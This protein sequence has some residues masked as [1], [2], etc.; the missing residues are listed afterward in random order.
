MDMKRG[1]GRDQGL[2]L[3]DPAA[4]APLGDWRARIAAAHARIAARVRR[5]PVLQLAAGSFGFDFDLALKLETCQHTGSY[6]PRGVFNRLLAR[7]D[8]NGSR[9][10]V[11]A[12]GGNHGIA[13]AHA[14]STLGFAA[15]VFVP[16]LT[17]PE[18]LRQI[19]ELGGEVMVSGANYGEALAASERHARETGALSIHAFDEPELIEGQG[20]VALELDQQAG[21]PDTVLVAAGGGSLLAGVCAWY[22][23]T[24]TRV[25][26]VEPVT[27]RAVG[28][29]LEAGEPVDV[30]VGG[31]AADSL[32]ARRAGRHTF[33]VIAP[34]VARM[35]TVEDAEIVAAQRAFWR[36]L[37]LVAEPG[38]AT[39]FAALLSGRYVPA[40]DERVAVIVCGANTDPARV[41]GEPAEARP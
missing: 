38:G 15:Q 39:A 24:A 26:G 31:V 28:A 32:G 22:A 41:R 13:V 23:G 4:Q 25:I 29:A 12:S 17:P 40:R 34:R 18:K 10:V 36:E 1:A 11:A 35:L 7:G 20:T 30:T 8:V 37:R 19:R 3:Y 16:T 9:T 33:K 14:A 6:K 2:A 27:A 5:T 21:A